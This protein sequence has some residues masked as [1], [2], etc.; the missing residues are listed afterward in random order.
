M[1]DKTTRKFVACNQALFLVSM[2]CIVL[3]FRIAT[4]HAYIFVVYLA[5]FSSKDRLK[6]KILGLICSIPTCRQNFGKPHGFINARCLS[7]KR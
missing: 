2:D 1:K 6:T 4:Y 3:M 5:L 7:S